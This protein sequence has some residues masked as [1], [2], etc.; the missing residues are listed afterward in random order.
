MWWCTA[1]S[2]AFNGN[3]SFLSISFLIWLDGS[4]I[5]LI[6]KTVSVNLQDTNKKMLIPRLFATW[7]LDRCQERDSSR[8]WNPQINHEAGGLNGL[9]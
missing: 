4:K 5:V 1:L 9:I 2:K 7:N 3:Q 8:Q 6:I